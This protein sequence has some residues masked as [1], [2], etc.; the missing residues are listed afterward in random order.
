MIA[1][2]RRPK[3]AWQITHIK[4]TTSFRENAYNLILGIVFMLE[5]AVWKVR[6]VQEKVLEVRKAGNDRGV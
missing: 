5:R 6:E 3:T 4:Q 1:G 2:R